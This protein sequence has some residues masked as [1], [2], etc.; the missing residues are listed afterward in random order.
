M[1]AVLEV[2]FGEDTGAQAP[3]GAL[4]RYLSETRAAVWRIA[5][6]FIASAAVRCVCTSPSPTRMDRQAA[7]SVDDDLDADLVE[8]MGTCR[9]R[10]RR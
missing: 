1:D 8:A 4:H 6:R 10:A 3:S 7:V 5:A 2:E 9:V